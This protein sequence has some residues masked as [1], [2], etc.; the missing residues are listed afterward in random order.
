MKGG[1][2]KPKKEREGERRRHG[3]RGRERKRKRMRAVKREEENR[4]CGVPWRPR[5]DRVPRRPS[6][7]SKEYN[8]VNLEKGPV[9]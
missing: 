3:E 4:E 1:R 8:K 9:D 2:E 6:K 7:V 5:A